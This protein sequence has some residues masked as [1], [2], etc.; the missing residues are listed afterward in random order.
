MYLNFS[1][2]LVKLFYGLKLKRYNTLVL[3]FMHWN[4]RISCLL[5]FCLWMLCFG[6]KQSF[7][8][9]S[10]HSFLCSLIFSVI[11]SFFYYLLC[12]SFCLFIHLFS[13]LSLFLSI[14]HLSDHFKMLNT[15]G[16]VL[17][18]LLKYEL[19]PLFFKND[20][21]HFWENATQF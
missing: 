17:S 3:N 2:L 1:K 6:A 18:V 9:I 5:S 12:L 7:V 8:L 13:F 4:P 16:K 11:H 19:L 10:F 20:T 14:L 15:G 21:K